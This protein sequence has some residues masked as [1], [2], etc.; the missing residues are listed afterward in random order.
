M[1]TAE[2]AE[3]RKQM[4]EEKEKILKSKYEEVFVK[5]NRS[6][7]RALQ[8]ALQKGAS[9]WHTTLPLTWLGYVL[10]KQEF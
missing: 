3:I 1:L 7:Q 5:E 10:N 8:N 2:E 6:N 4:K 9:T